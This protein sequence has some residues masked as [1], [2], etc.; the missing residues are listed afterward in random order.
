MAHN[1]TTIRDALTTLFGSLTFPVWTEA[2]G[3]RVD[4]SLRP[5]AVFALASDV[6]DEISMGEPFRVGW[7]Q[8][9]AIEMHADGAEGNAVGA[10]ID[11]MQLE[12]EAAL[13]SSPTLSDSIQ[14][15]EPVGS[16]IEWN[17]SQ[18]RVIAQR[19]ANYLLHWRAQFG[20]PDV[21]E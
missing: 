13:A 16:E 20:T 11:A 15:I 10:Q 18:D 3:T 21:P 5:V 19:T 9:L 6:A 7:A 8:E 2:P 17:S 12:I 4:T 1:R 14:R